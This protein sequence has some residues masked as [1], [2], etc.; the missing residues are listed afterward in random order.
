MAVAGCFAL[1]RFSRLVQVAHVVVDDLEGFLDGR[2]G[3]IEIAKRQRVVASAILESLRCRCLN[4]SQVGLWIL[5]RASIIRLHA[6]RDV[7]LAAFLIFQIQLHRRRWLLWV[8]LVAIVV[9]VVDAPPVLGRD[10]EDVRCL[11]IHRS[12]PHRCACFTRPNL[13]W[14]TVRLPLFQHRDDRAFGRLA[15][16]HSFA[17]HHLERIDPSHQSLPRGL[18]PLTLLDF[19]FLDVHL[20]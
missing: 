18:D 9:S 11:T 1:S 2:G 20:A 5:D 17:W 13:E 19:D 10:I 7:E 6:Q 4:D 3:R 14:V 8:E 16:L 15:N 12:R